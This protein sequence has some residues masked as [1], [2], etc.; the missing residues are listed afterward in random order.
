M[1]RTATLRL[2]CRLAGRH[3]L[4]AVPLYGWAEPLPGAALVDGGVLDVAPG[5]RNVATGELAHDI[6]ETKTPHGS[7]FTDAK[8]LDALVLMI[9]DLLELY[10]EDTGETVDRIM[11]RLPS[12]LNQAA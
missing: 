4:A 5:A 8:N 11:L 7:L 6:S 1:S 12:P 10:S 9:K 3:P 2:G